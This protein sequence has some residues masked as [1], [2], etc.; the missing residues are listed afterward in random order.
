MEC[1][2]LSPN[3]ESNDKFHITQKEKKIRKMKQ[4]LALVKLSAEK[5]TTNVKILNFFCKLVKTIN[6]MRAYKFNL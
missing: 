6:F 1:V 2:F 5:N 4:S 3:A